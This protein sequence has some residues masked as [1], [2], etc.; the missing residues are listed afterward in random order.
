MLDRITLRGFR[1][2]AD[3]TALGL[4]PL[5]VLAG[6]NNTGKSSF[7]G[8]LLALVQS[9]QAASRHHLLLDG[10][11]V[12]LG[13]FD[14]LLSPDHQT[15]SIG[16]EGRIGTTPLDVIWD[17]AEE[18]NRRNRAVARVTKIEAVLGDDHLEHEVGSDGMLVG[19]SGARLLHPASVFRGAE[20][21]LRLSP[22]ASAQVLAVG[23]YRAPAQRLSPFRVGDDGS[24]VGK[25]GQLQE[26]GAHR[27]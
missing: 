15:F 4:G 6:A 3:T 11:W 23:P 8:A 16:V 13:P 9:Q 7:I 2:C 10:E 12:D 22:Y 25:F 18:P 1:A 26:L 20:A 5:T 21:E 24:L 17:F 27:L 19:A 14:E